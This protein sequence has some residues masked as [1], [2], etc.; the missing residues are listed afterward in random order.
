[1]FL[2]SMPSSTLVYA[3][4]R[5]S[6]PFRTAVSLPVGADLVA[7]SSA[8]FEF[9]AEVP[10]DVQHGSLTNL[11]K[12]CFSYLHGISKVAAVGFCA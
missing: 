5:S 7:F 11:P 8:F 10:E 6:L 9:A 2:R 4:L 1:M 12:I 3:E